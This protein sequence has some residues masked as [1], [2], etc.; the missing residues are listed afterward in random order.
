MAKPPPAGANPVA[1]ELANKLPIYRKEVIAHKDEAFFLHQTAQEFRNYEE[2]NHEQIAVS[3]KEVIGRSEDNNR[4]SSIVAQKIKDLKAKLLELK[5]EISMVRQSIKEA[6]EQFSQMT[7]M[8]NSD[9]TEK[10]ERILTELREVEALLAH[11]A[12]WQR[13]ADSFK[14]HLSELKSTIHHNRVMCSEGI[15]ETR[16]SAQA[17]IE[18]HR[19]KLAEAIRQARAES[20]RLRSG[21]ISDLSAT[22]LTQAEG[23]LHSLNSQ[24]ESSDHL[25]LVNQTIDDD[26]ASM[27]R[28]IERLSRRRTLLKEQEEKQKTVLVKLKAIKKEF[29]DRQAADEQLKKSQSLRLI[30]EQKR[31]E[32]DALARSLR[33]QKPPFKM[34]EEQEAFVTFLNE[35]ATSVK[36]VMV[37]LLGEERGPVTVSPNERFEAPKLSAMIAQIKDMTPKIGELRP[38]TPGGSTKHVLTPAAAYFAF[39]APF[40]EGDDFIASESWSF[41]KYEPTKP[42]AQDKRA[43][44][45]RMRT[46][47]AHKG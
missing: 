44:I 6:E 35:C 28:E 1:L 41:A 16:Q 19:V 45:V 11:Y 23:H 14:S 12:E 24:I 21:D 13:M 39:S 7:T 18:K 38:T 36:S 27:M 42:S 47:G 43:R 22:F 8:A 30:E 40:D 26:N 5:G 15:A 20:L 31:V 33:I 29:A 4:M 3:E 32:A 17:K 2:Q 9:F 37:D 10:K 34:N 25:S 46:K